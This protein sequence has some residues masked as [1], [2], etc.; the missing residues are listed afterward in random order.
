[1][2][3]IMLSSGG[4][5][6]EGPMTDFD[7]ALTGFAHLDE[8]ALGRPW[9]WRG[10]TLDL[11]YAL[12]RTLEEA[13]EACVAVVGGPHPESRRILALAQRAF[14]ELRGLL[15]GLPTELIDREPRSGEWPVREVLR[16]MLSVERRYAVQTRYAVDRADADPVRI[17]EGRLPPTAPAEVGGDIAAVLARLAQARSETN[18]RLCDLAP[19]ALT[20]PSLWVKVEIDVRFR[21]HRFAAHVI[22]HTIQCE[23][24]LAALGWHPTE[25][26]RIVRQLAG[27]LGELEGFGALAAVRV[28]EAAL[29]ERFV[30]LGAAVSRAGA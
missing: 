7:A 11:R 13:Q 23:K 27:V 24:T 5:R 26:R 30:S 15:I 19:A 3:G 20:R 25:G 18:R 28:I 16:H 29:T 22:E 9:R 17:P 8:D 21:L 14:G 10:G 2:G 4:G 12:Y 1:V 6:Q